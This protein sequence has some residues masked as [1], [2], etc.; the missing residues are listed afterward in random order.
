MP[1]RQVR[2]E[3]R[4]ASRRLGSS[5]LGSR[6]QGSDE[7]GSDGSLAFAESL[8][9]QP[10]PLPELCRRH[11]PVA[12]RT[13]MAITS[14]PADSSEAVS[15]AFTEVLSSAGDDVGLAYNHLRPQLIAATREVA[16]STLR[17]SGPA[18]GSQQVAP[19]LRDGAPL[20]APVGAPVGT[21][22]FATRVLGAF[23]SLPERW[24]S[25]LWLVE[26][27]N[28][29]AAEAAR[30]IGVEVAEVATLKARAWA[31]LVEL[32]PPGEHLEPTDLSC[33]PTADRLTSHF[34]GS[35]STAQRA[36]VDA[37]LSNCGSCQARLNQLQELATTLRQ[38]V[39]PLPEGLLSAATAGWSNGEPPRSEPT[40]ALRG[41]VSRPLVRAWLAALGLAIIGVAVLDQASAPLAPQ[42]LAAAGNL[43]ANAPDV[44]VIQ[45]KPPS[46]TA[47]GRPLGG[48]AAKDT[49]SVGGLAGAGVNPSGSPP[50][51]STPS[52]EGSGSG[53]TGPAPTGPAPTGSG[54]N[55]TP[56]N[57]SA[58]KGSNTNRSTGT[59]SGGTGP[60]P[61][62]LPTVVA[63]VGGLPSGTQ[64]GGGLLPQVSVDIGLGGIP[65]ALNVG[66]CTGL[67][68]AFLS[69]GCAP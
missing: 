53:G 13:A 4:L 46:T 19:S 38:V 55:T 59:G 45:T 56:S 32:S 60:S 67:E 6:R 48:T 50:Q 24:R 37:H 41:E 26:V 63:P 31:G 52:P 8:R 49:Q 20:G 35:L 25:V 28:I 17:R 22:V 64:S 44:T 36:E 42:A 7:P 33:K 2:A 16:V 3:H 14:N 10:R 21:Q 62:V 68:L 61:L 65:V 39:V 18:Q 9:G 1:T 40:A 58:G 47:T 29:P 43:V 15:Q 57:G 34:S 23:R 12:W 30:I 69:L 11:V 66:A 27:E 54:T 51:G 5:R